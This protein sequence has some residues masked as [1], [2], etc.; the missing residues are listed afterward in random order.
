LVLDALFDTTTKEL[1]DLDAICHWDLKALYTLAV[2]HQ[3]LE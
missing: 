3:A 2:D 1:G